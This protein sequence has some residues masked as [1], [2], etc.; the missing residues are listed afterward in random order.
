MLSNPSRQSLLPDSD[1]ASRNLAW[2][3]WA[4]PLGF[5]AMYLP[6]YWQAANGLWQT[7]EFGHGPLM[8]LVAGWLFWR[9]RAD[10]SAAPTQPNAA[11]G[12]PLFVLGLL[13]YLFGRV[14]NVSSVEFLSQA[15]MVAALLLL[16]KGA[17]AIK[18][19]WFA[20]FYLLFVVPLPATI[21]DM[22]TAPLKKWISTLIVDGLFALGYPIS[23]TGVMISIGQYQLLVAD[24]CSGLNSMFSLSAL[25]TLYM[26]LMKRGSWVHNSLMLLSIL[27]IAFAANI[28][29][30]VIL[31]LITYHFGDEAGQGFLHGAAG[32]VLMLVALLLF[33]SVDLVLLRLRRQP[34]MASAKA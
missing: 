6:S 18:V 9:L 10:I 20:L 26:Y 19:A 32:I 7:E 29:R 14:V 31:V 8:L 15:M 5:A 30:V 27:P 13:A 17:A 1:P 16:F 3:L 12:W 33:F 25:G 11:I 4:A 2:L 23:R 22:L 24:A 34:L 28:I 21:T